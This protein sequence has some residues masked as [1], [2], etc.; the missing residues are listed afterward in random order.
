M[1]KHAFDE[2]KQNRNQI[3]GNRLTFSARIAS[4]Q[5]IDDESHRRGFDITNSKTPTNRDLQDDL[6]QLELLAISFLDEH[7][8]LNWPGLFT[9]GGIPTAICTSV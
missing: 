9:E 3:F 1:Q 8:E 6:L 2:L 7:P 4:Q 5:H